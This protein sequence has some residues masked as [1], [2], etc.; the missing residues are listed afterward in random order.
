MAVELGAAY[1]SILPSTSKLAPEL[2]KSM[3]KTV[4]KVG[5]QAGQTMGSRMA[6]AAGK[7]LKAGAVVGVAA[8]GAAVGT[9]LVGGFRNAVSRQNSQKVLSG[10]YGSAKDATAVMKDLRKVSS[11]SPLNYESYLKAAESLAYAGVEGKEATGTLKN[12]GKAI[13][14]AGGD[15]TK[16]DQAMGGVM[17]AVN[18]GGIAMMDSLSMISESGVPILSGLS[19]K[20]GKPIDQIKKMASE[21]KI[22]ITDVMDVMQNGTGETFQKMMKAGDSA[23]QSFGNQW[24][25]AK[26]NV[27]NA[28]GD[29]MLPLMDQL[30]PMIKPAA[31]A[32]VDF[33]EKIPGMVEGIKA[34]VQWVKDNV[35]WLSTLAATL[36][37][38]GVA[39]WV[40]TGGLTAVGVAIKG[41]FLAISTGIKSIPVIGWVIAA[42]GLLVTA[43]V[44]FFTK[45][46]TGQKIWATVW[47]GIKTATAAVVGWFQTYVWPV[48]KAVW[49]GIL[50]GA[51]WL[52]NG[53]K[54][55]WNGIMVAVQAVVAWF[56]TYVA[57][58]IKAVF[59]A[60]GAVFTWLWKNIAAPVFKGIK[61]IVT[62][63]WAGVKIIFN[64][65]I[66]FVKSYLAPVFQLFWAIIKVVW[67]GIRVAIN[68]A[69]QFIKKYI[70]TPIVN[71]V[72]NQL[73]PRFKFLQAVLKLVWV[74]IQYYIQVAWAFIK[75]HVFQPIV[76]WINT[77]LAPK[78]KFLRDT[79]K[80]VWAKIKSSIST[81]WN[82]VRDKVFNPLKNAISKSVPNAFEKGKDAIGKAWDKVKNIAKTPVKFVV[83]TVINK[84]IIGGFNKIASKFG[85]KEMPEFKLPKGF[86]TGG[87]VSGP[88]TSTSDSIPARLSNNEHVL[89][90]KDVKNMGGHSNVYALRSAAAKGWTPGLATGGTLSDAARWLQSKG[91]RITEFGAWGQRVGRH[92]NGSLH[93]S[94]RAFDANYGPGGENATEKRFFDSIIGR[95]HEKFP[96]L[97][98]IWRAPGH[99][100]HFHADTS[101]GGSIGSGGSGSDGFNILDPLLKPFKD[102]KKKIADGVGNT[103]FG[104]LVGAGAKKMVNAPI[105]WI[106]DNISKVA[107]FFGDVGSK[108]K[109]GITKGVAWGKGQAWAASRGLNPKELGWMN[110]I[111]SKESGWNPKAQNPRSTAS[112]LPQFVNG[113]ARQYLGGAPAK[114]YG[115]FKQLDGMNRYV[116]SSKFDR[117]GGGWK[118][119]YNYWQKHNYYAKGTLSAARG[120]ATVGENGPE[121]LKLRGGEQIK[122]NRNSRRFIESQADS[123][124]VVLNVD[125]HGRVDDPNEMINKLNFFVERKFG[126]GKYARG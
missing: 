44:W 83:D 73:V 118:G 99:Y 103:G 58:V 50:A 25:I 42:I 61:L 65:V 81:V 38:A 98:T 120:W 32:M 23:S 40:A 108:V 125:F 123:D 91:A 21:G 76:N 8:V 96:N 46:K 59:S 126:S 74:K 87:R 84:G 80:N 71:F 82:F 67:K 79:V 14:A 47:N 101:K 111:V 72:N 19:E 54:L 3:N 77:H 105:N 36:T 24:K 45:T 104:K 20:F 89:T 56:Q 85:V 26:D 17:K 69:W 55:V 57:P 75:K 106:K 2:Y 100:N 31:D 43:L 33:I 35:V 9:A 30:A 10:L 110:W 7:A 92:S 64:A 107:G 113:T 12:V 86:R 60:I 28:V 90:A 115:V 6:S 66:N 68:A 119:A 37:V 29:S 15:S 97:R 34:G 16:L 122:S 114:K 39:S 48:M 5:N 102:L 117:Y 41:V 116:H 95:F 51:Q 121:L 1:I 70:F 49:D 109:G 4:P 78:F 27:V 88:G 62:S 13:V 18:N 112:G 22:N 63:W 94:G 93:Y 52:W 124:R 11:D 53:I